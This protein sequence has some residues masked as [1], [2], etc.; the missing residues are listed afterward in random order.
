MNTRH[1]KRKVQQQFENTTNA[2]K[3]KHDRNLS[4]TT[5][6]IT[7]PRKIADQLRKNA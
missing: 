3:K 5:S 6:F 7:I 1:F 4:K 2:L